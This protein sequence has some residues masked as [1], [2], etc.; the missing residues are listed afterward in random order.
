MKALTETTKNALW[1]GVFALIVVAA[2]TAWS[3]IVVS[4]LTDSAELG[5]LGVMNLMFVAGGLI[6]AG[7]AGRL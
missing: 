5:W 2:I 1:T 6:V 4:I 3:M 7:A